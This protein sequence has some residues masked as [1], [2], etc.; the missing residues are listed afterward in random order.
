MAPQ[1][2]G[3]R[4]FSAD[5]CMPSPV[6][7]HQGTIQPRMVREEVGNRRL[8]QQG[9]LGLWKNLS[10]LGQRRLAHDGVAQ[11]IGTTNNDTVNALLTHNQSSPPAGRTATV[12]PVD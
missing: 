12:V 9:D 11:P 1:Y 3:Q 8:H 7:I 10:H 4:P 6:I 5:A 2:P